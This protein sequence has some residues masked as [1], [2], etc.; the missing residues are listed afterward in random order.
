M[1]TKFGT[2]PYLEFYDWLKNAL[3]YIRSGR[4]KAA[5]LAN[6]RSLS[7]LHAC[8]PMIFVGYMSLALLIIS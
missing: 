4:M 1:A 5:S 6:H 7:M 8:F 3:E 2:I